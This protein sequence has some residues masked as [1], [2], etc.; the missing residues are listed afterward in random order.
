M[1]RLILL[2]AALLAAAPLSAQSI[3]GRLVHSGSGQPI[4][5]AMVWL[6]DPTGAQPRA[7]ITDEEGRFLLQAP[8][9]GRYTVRAE[10]VGF[11]SATSPELVLAAHQTLEL[12]LESAEQVIALEEIVVEGEKRCVVRPEVGRESARVW[13]EARKALSA[14]AWTSEHGL[15]RF[16]LIGYERRLDPRTLRAGAETRW[17]KSVL[18]RNPITSAP[19]QELAEHGYI[20]QT[21]EGS[22]DY[23]GLDAHVLLSDIF[24]DH[25][26]FRLRQGKGKE[27]GLVG[28]AFEPVQKSDRADVAGV[29]WLD[30]RTAELRH[31]EFRYTKL[32]WSVPNGNLGGR[33][34]FERLPHGAWIVRHW[35]IRAPLVARTR[36]GRIT[37]IGIQEYG[38][39]VGAIFTL[40]GEPVA[41]SRFRR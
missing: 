26:C 18:A 19:A 7:V 3:R 25:H 39:E 2:L 31:L 38:N 14:A 34:E 20:R 16:E 30:P 29:L 17:A 5:G 15:L 4:G 8:A 10:R 6:L 40:A 32:P 36:S 27:Q 37:L 33:V 9:P 35:W 21:P 13:D 24:L 12:R 28:L 1:R 41:P 11:S 23:F 22:F